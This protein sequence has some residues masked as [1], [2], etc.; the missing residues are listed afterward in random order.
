M[1]KLSTL[2]RGFTMLELLIAV[3]IVTIL[4]SAT[5]VTLRSQ[6]ARARDARRRAD[7]E[8]IRTALAFYRQ[9]KHTYPNEV[10]TPGA[11][12]WEISTAGNFLQLLITEGAM[13]TVPRDPR[14]THVNTGATA[15]FLPRPN[16]DYYYA[17]YL[18]NEDSANP[19]GT[20]GSAYGCNFDG[21]FAVVGIKSFESEPPDGL[22]RAQCGMNHSSAA[23]GCTDGGENLGTANACRDWGNEFDY[24]IIV[25]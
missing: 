2:S 1:K 24:S 8:Q 18:Y 25:R 19:A 3:S 13:T 7:I 10:S 22:P 6:S 16:G 4:A 15:P 12:D 11:S 23:D 9:T 5:L 21:T 17:Y 20:G 14:N